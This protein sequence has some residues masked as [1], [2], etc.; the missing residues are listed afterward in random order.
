MS[1]NHEL[2]LAIST[3]W[4]VRRHSEP[5]SMLDEILSLGARR[6]ELSNITAPLLPGLPEA[7]AERG[8]VV[9]SIHNPC[10]WPLDGNGERAHW[11]APDVLASLEPAE[12]TRGLAMGRRSIEIAQQL[13]AGAVVVHLGRV[14]IER[15]QAELFALLREG[16]RAEFEALRAE[17]LAE[18]AAHAPAHLEAA[19]ASIRELGEHAAAAGVRLGVETRDGYFE[20]PSL[21]EFDAVFAATAGLPVDYWHDIGHADRQLQLGI[22]TPEQYLSRFG[23]RLLGVHLHDALFDRDHKAPGQGTINFHA[24]ARALPKGILRTVEF[25]PSVTYEEACAGLE[26]LKQAGLA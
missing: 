2:T 13:G 18:R 9:Q 25:G 1:A 15:L 10:P 26:V 22:A 17:T 16:K 19:L 21:A 7:L 11:F 4:N 6:V 3:N 14:E 20:M 23:S 5:G 12:R 8:M 24:L